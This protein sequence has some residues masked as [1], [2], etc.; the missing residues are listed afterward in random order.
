MV[1]TYA[2]EGV[3]L[4]TRRDSSGAMIVFLNIEN[5]ESNEKQR[6]RVNVSRNSFISGTGNT[7]RGA[8]TVVFG[9]DPHI[10]A[11]CLQFVD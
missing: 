2:F 1:C 4:E 6:V 8:G 9:A 11:D 7:V 3:V 5:P 10:I